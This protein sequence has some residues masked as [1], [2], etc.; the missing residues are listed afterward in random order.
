MIVRG[1]IR[2]ADLEERPPGSEQIELM[3]RV[4]GVGPG[5][6]RVIVVPH[7]LLI[8]DPS[9]DPE[10]M[11]GRSFAAEVSVD[12]EV[13]WIVSQISLGARALREER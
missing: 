3:L 7:G 10:A 5:Q 13:R 1:F 9:L 8:S 6:P 4:Q 12:A 2:S 11:A